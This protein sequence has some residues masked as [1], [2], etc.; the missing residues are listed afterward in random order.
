MWEAGYTDAYVMHLKSGRM[1][2]VDGDRLSLSLSAGGTYWFSLSP[3]GS[4]H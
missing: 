4:R 1:E 2:F 3:A